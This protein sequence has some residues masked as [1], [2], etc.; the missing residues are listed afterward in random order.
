MIEENYEVSFEYPVMNEVMKILKEEHADIFGQESENTCKIR[1][2]IRRSS[3]IKIT[4]RLQ[5]IQGLKS[6]FLH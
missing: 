4:S 2:S 1:F 5:K 3:G 6:A